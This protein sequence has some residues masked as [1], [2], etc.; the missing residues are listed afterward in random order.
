MLLCV[1]LF[2]GCRLGGTWHRTAVDPA[3]ATFPLERITFEGDRFTA[4]RETE[5]GTR[6]TTGTYVWNG[7]ALSLRSADGADGEYGCRRSVDG[8]RLFLTRQRLVPQPTA[9]F[10]RIEP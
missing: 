3:G 1:A 5:E 9:T 10:E 2:A 4:T 6:T 7:R 8:D